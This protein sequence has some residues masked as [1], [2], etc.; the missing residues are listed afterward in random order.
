[1]LKDMSNNINKGLYM[2]NSPFELTQDDRNPLDLVEDLA[3]HK[4][5]YYERITASKLTLQMA[6]QRSKYNVQLEWQEEFCAL[7]FSCFLDM[8]VDPKFQS[9]AADLLMRTND[10]LWLGHFIIDQETNQPTFR[11]TMMLEH[12]PCAVSIEMIS[13]LMDLVITECDRFYTTFQMLA[14]GVIENRETLYTAMM[15]TIGEA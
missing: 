14:N 10:G 7:Q 15:E 12:V 1:M 2:L 5:W 13:D 11:Y 4:S 8:N 9:I 3:G 6:G